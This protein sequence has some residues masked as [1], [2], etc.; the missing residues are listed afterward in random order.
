M[1]GSYKHTQCGYMI[2]ATLGLGLLFI[3]AFGSWALLTN[4]DWVAFAVLVAVVALLAMSLLLFSTLTVTVTVAVAGGVLEVR[5]GPV[6]LL[7]KRFALGDIESCQAV[8][9]RWWYGWGVRLTPRGWL[10]NV[11]G[12]DAVEI[13]MK[14]GKTYRIGTNEPQ[15]LEA[16]LRGAIGI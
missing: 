1:A 12:L 13:K 14:N 11:S 3:I 8:K 9:N 6:S 15:A 16:A 4:F 10:F 2:L 5:F 7:R